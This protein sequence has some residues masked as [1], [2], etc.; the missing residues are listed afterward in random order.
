MLQRYRVTVTY[1]IP[2]NNSKYTEILHPR[3]NTVDAAVQ[4]SLLSLPLAAR[5][6]RINVE[7]A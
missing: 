5:I 3:A 4:T 1:S 7:L 6:E 2:G